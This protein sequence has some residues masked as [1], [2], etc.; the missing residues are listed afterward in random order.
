MLKLNSFFV[1]YTFIF[2]LLHYELISLT[3]ALFDMLFA[4]GQLAARWSIEQATQVQF[5]L[6]LSFFLLSTMYIMVLE[7]NILI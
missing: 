5:L 2:E 1:I 3:K 7:V 6:T 4:I